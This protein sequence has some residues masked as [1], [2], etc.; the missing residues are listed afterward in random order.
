MVLGLGFGVQKPSRI[1][2]EFSLTNISGLTAW[3]KF[4]TGITTSGSTVTLWDDS[5][6]NNRKMGNI[7]ATNK[8]PVFDS[9]D[10]TLNFTSD[11]FL[12][13]NSTYG[14]DTVFP[15]SNEF[16]AF[17]AVRIP[18]DSSTQQINPILSNSSA[19][20]AASI[21]NIT[22][23]TGSFYN[24]IGDTDSDYGHSDTSETVHP[25]VNNELFVY[26]IRRV[27][28]LLQ[29]FRNSRLNSISQTTESNTTL[30][31]EINELGTSNAA[32]VNSVS[33]A[34]VAVYNSGLSDA[35]FDSVINDIK[36]RVG[37]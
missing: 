22:F 3:Y 33:I 13:L 1:D 29:L 34:E 11:R 5:S 12:E 6:G 35:N 10:N 28:T 23:F 21:G 37:I 19:V 14:T 32:I 8:R 36:T 15:N 4:N 24:L 27:G 26:A 16:T 30:K 7:T 25:H 9:S 31:F 18:F 20:D 2:G 17:L